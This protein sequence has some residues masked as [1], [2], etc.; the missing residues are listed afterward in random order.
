MDRMPPPGR[1]LSSP[2]KRCLIVASQISSIHDLTVETDARLMEMDFGTWEGKPWSDIDRGEIDH[3][4][5]DF[6][7]ARPHGGES[8]DQLYRRVTSALSEYDSQPMLNTLVITHAGVIRAALACRNIPGAWNS[9]IA[10]GQK[11][12]LN[13]NALALEDGS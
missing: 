11:V 6:F 13:E 2:L 3:W 5:A 12:V 4:A 9:Q 7:R 1:L 8:V 10:Y